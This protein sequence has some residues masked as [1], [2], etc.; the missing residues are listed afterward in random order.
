M[1]SER[2]SLNMPGPASQELP[3]YYGDRTAE[4]ILRWAL[5]R[6]H[7][8]IAIA[9][10]LQDS[11]LIHMATR[12]RKD[13]R[14]FSIDTGRLPEETYMCAEE[15]GRQLGVRI[16]WYFPRHDAVERLATENGVFSFK[17]SLEDRREC[18]F[19]RKVEPLNRA[20]AGLDAWIT[21]LRRD[22]SVT[23]TSLERIERDEAHGGI[24][25]I[26]ALADWS[27]DDVRAYLLKHRIPYNRLLD[28]GYSSIGCACC[29]RPVDPGEDPRAGRWWWER[30]EHKEC[31]LHVRNWSI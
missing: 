12:I 23:R 13:A 9:T 14:A 18:C 24:L 7:P 31:G 11:A 21:G 5:D 8:R 2:E 15:I 19:I 4:D 29:S 30:P 25:K 3:A 17:I 22:E 20:L 1:R 10:S 27:S 6:F 16:E 28:Q 26:N